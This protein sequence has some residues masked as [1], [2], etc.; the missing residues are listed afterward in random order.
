MN[1]ESLWTRFNDL[2]Q[3]LILCSFSLRLEERK[4]KLLELHLIGA[5]LE[6][7]VL[8]RQDEYQA[9][10]RMEGLVYRASS[11]VSA[12]EQC[13]NIREKGGRLYS[14]VGY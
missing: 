14:Y 3:E 11:A 9:V 2:A 12:A 13:E 4:D 5:R 7:L 10:C 1:E 6:Q 8:N